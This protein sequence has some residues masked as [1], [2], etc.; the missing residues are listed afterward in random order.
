MVSMYRFT[1]GSHGDYEE[2]HENAFEHLIQTT[3]LKRFWQKNNEKLPNKLFS[4]LKIP[5][6]QAV[7]S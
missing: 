6:F 5:T 2:D 3:I 1:S 4:S 7:G